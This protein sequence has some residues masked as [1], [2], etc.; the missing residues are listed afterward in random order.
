MSGYPL[1]NLEKAARL[2][3][4]RL[5]KFFLQLLRQPVNGVTGLAFQ[6]NQLGIFSEFD[7]YFFA[8]LLVGLVVIGG[9]GMISLQ[10]SVAGFSLV[11]PER[12]DHLSGEQVL[13]H[14]NPPLKSLSL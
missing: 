10:S 13:D 9:E 1:E 12:A 2:C 4:K 14:R 11:I 3:S 6:K 7:P 8:Q 5:L